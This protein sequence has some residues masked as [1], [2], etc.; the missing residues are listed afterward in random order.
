MNSIKLTIIMININ[1]TAKVMELIS[2]ISLLLYH[3]LNNKENLDLNL[4]INLMLCSLAL[5]WIALFPVSLKSKESIYNRKLK[6]KGIFLII[7][8]SLSAFSIIFCFF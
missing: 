7:G 3:F 1:K 8:F 2:V 6:I 5:Y 4:S